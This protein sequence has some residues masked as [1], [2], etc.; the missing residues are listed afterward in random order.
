[1]KVFHNEDGRSFRY[2]DGHRVYLDHGSISKPNNASK[3]DG[4]SKGEDMRN[5]VHLTD[6]IERLEA[7]EERAGVRIEALYAAFMAGSG[8]QVR[9]VF[10]NGIAVNGEVHPRE[11]VNLPHPVT[12]TADAYDCQGRLVQSANF[13]LEPAKFF[14]YETFSLGLYCGAAQVA[15]IRVYPKVGHR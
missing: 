13:T 8:T 1:L 5:K 11:G 4:T 3:H 10:Y 12:I 14:G 9:G 6:L 7:F 15:K 2:A